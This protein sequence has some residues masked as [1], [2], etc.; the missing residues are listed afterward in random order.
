[1]GGSRAEPCYSAQKAFK[2][3]PSEALPLPTVIDLK[4]QFACVHLHP[5]PSSPLPYA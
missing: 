1:M 4:E 5:E 2:P 3:H